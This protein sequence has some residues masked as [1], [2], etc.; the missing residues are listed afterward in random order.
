MVSAPHST[1]VLRTYL[2]KG[3]IAQLGLLL[4]LPCLLLVGGTS[5]Q[6][7]FILVFSENIYQDGHFASVF[8][9]FSD[10][11]TGPGVSVN[12]TNMMISISIMF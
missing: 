11:D 9:Y 10:G 1:S 12:F 4:L 2:E 8:T 5:I 6:K 3:G 7:Y